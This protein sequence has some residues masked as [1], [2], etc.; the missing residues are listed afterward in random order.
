MHD[1]KP[2][3]RKNLFELW[4]GLL[5]R[6]RTR[7][8]AGMVFLGI[9]AMTNGALVVAA[10]E[11]RTYGRMGTVASASDEPGRFTFWVSWHAV[12]AVILDI[13]LLCALV[14]WWRDRRRAGSSA[15]R[16]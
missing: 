5:R 7:W 6:E 2:W 12:A 4:L 16:S 9:T 13:I 14:A 1:E 3:W 8:I 15:A 11:G 10:L